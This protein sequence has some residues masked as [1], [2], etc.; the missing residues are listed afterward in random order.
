MDPKFEQSLVYYVFPTYI[1]LKALCNNSHI[2]QM[3]TFKKNRFYRSTAIRFD[4]HESIEI[5]C[6]IMFAFYRKCF[7]ARYL[8]GAKR[9]Y[10]PFLDKCLEEELDP[11]FKIN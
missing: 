9:H 6:T 8:I 11:Y 3:R 7:L 4:Q 1:D 10:D 5:N 2:Y